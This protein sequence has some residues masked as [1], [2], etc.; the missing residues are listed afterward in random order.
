MVIEVIMWDD[1]IWLYLVVVIG[2]LCW[3]VLHWLSDRQQ[4]PETSSHAG[5]PW[6]LTLP[7]SAPLPFQQTSLL[8]SL[9]CSEASSIQD[10]KR[11]SSTNPCDRRLLSIKSTHQTNFTAFLTAFYFSLTGFCLISVLF[12]FDVVCYTKLV[13]VSCW[14][15][16]SKYLHIIL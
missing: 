14:L 6:H 8:C 3:S 4:W 16:A 13:I 5:S 15:H 7:R 10:L 12:M 11:T 1:C 2:L 9:Q